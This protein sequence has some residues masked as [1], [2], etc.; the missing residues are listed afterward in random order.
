MSEKIY[1]KGIFIKKPE[2]T[3]DFVLGRMGVKTEDFI[4]FLHEHT[5]ANGFCDFDLLQGDKGP[6]LVLNTYKKEEPKD[7]PT[8]QMGVDDED[9]ANLPF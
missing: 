4:N 8:V 6:Y 9:P 2:N 5:K 3:P 1:P 7:E